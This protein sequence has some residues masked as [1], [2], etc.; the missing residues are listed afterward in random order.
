MVPSLIAD[1]I[2]LPS[3]A[4]SIGGG[5]MKIPS[6]SVL[7]GRT[8][9]AFARSTRA[10]GG[11]RVSN[12]V[13]SFQQSCESHTLALGVGERAQRSHAARDRWEQYSTT[14]S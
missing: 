14:E 2:C 10:L 11:V 3:R 9:D 12:G 1:R 5:R 4:G 6:R 8:P 13:F 7:V